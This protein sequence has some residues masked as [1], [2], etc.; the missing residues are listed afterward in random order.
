MKD[1]VERFSNRV[2]NYVKYRP[3]YP[4]AAAD[5]LSEAIALTPDEQI[6]DI[7]CGTGISSKL[8][9]EN[10]NTVIG[11]EPNDAMRSAAE[12]YLAGYPRFRAIKGTAEATTLATH[13]VDVVVAG[14]AFHW[15]DLDKTKPEFERIVRPGGHVVLMWNERQLE[16]TPFLR[17]YEQFIVKYSS[18]YA[19]VRHDTF[20]AKVIG[21]FFD[22]PVSKAVFPNVQHLELDGLKGRMLS[23]SYMPNEQDAVFPEMMDGLETLFAKHSENDRINILY[24]T[25][26]YV[27]QF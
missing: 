7:G 24:D 4:P 18:D 10:G 26:V 25:N 27:S 17:E 20:D 23:A 2:D 8:F 12:E 3:H 15:F 11:V 13:S 5:Y 9:L 22:R 1:T 14:Q 6:A 19:V 21:Q 16:T